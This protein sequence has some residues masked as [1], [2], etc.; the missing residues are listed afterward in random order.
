[1]KKKNLSAKLCLKKNNVASFEVQ[2]VTG[3]TGHTGNCPPPT[4]YDICGTNNCQTNANCGSNG[5][6]TNVTCLTDV[7]LSCTPQ[8]CGNSLFVC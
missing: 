6:G 3:G 1:M 2:K 8:G 5:C 4:I 7:A